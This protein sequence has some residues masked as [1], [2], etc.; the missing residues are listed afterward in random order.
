MQFPSAKFQPDIGYRSDGAHL[1]GKGGGEKSKSYPRNEGS[2]KLFCQY[3]LKRAF[4]ATGLDSRPLC[5]TLSTRFSGLSSISL[6]L[7]GRTSSSFCRGLK[8]PSASP[9]FYF[10]ILCS[11]TRLF[12]PH[13]APPTIFP[14][15]P[16]SLAS[17]TPKNVWDR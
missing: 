10:S 7:S 6:L 3:L 9:S 17:V 8:N 11:L 15:Q 2:G 4:N 12:C 1:E 16:T 13:L 5:A 14:S